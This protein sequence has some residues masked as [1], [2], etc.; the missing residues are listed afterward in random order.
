MTGWDRMTAAIKDI[1]TEAEVIME[2]NKKDDK[3]ADVDKMDAKTL[4][5]HKMNIILTKCNPEKINTA[6]GGQCF[7]PFSVWHACTRFPCCPFPGDT[8]FGFEERVVSSRGSV[9]R[10]V[11]D[12]ALRH[13]LPCPASQPS[14][15]RGSPSSRSSRSSSLAPSPS[16]SPGFRCRLRLSAAGLLAQLSAS[17]GLLLLLRG[18]VG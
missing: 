5:A 12:R 10:E 2:E 7:T 4:A 13:S 3:I 14:T 17:L 18:L 15:P 16:V 9:F 8:L 11:T 6:L 1:T